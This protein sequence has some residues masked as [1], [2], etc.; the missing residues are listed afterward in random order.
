MRASGVKIVFLVS[1]LRQTGPTMQLL[2][3]VRYLDRN[4]FEPHVVTLSPESGASML[5]S[6]T[7]LGVDVKSL[8]LSRLRGMFHRGWRDD[9]RRAVGA[10]LD[11]GCVIHSQGIRADVISSQR[12]IGVPR[13]ATARNYPHHDYLMKFGPLQGRWMAREHLR[14]FRS[15]PTVVA[16]SST[17]AGL[18]S[19]HGIMATVIRNGV[20]A[21]NFAPPTPQ[22]RA[23][24]R[25][26]LGLPDGA[27]VGVCVG[28]LEPRKDPLHVIRAMRAIDAP[29]LVLV[30]VGGGRLENECRR[31]AQPDPRIRFTG[32]ITNVATYLRAADFIVSASRSEGMPNAILEAIAC[33][34]RVVLSDIE[35]HREL[36]QLVPWAGELFAIDD[37]SALISA[38]G[39]TSL[40]VAAEQARDAA[41]TMAIVGAEQVS[42]Q[43]QEL[44][45]RLADS[46][47]PRR[48]GG[49][50]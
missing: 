29:D 42:Q 10:D 23:R 44:Y 48:A 8:A 49:T 6:F 15:L 16:C 50:A 34:L 24:L 2:N 30:F 47:R 4:L 14:A 18:L 1:T 28:S 45:S 37:T 17:L 39:R 41:R 43:Y 36:L 32:H 5:D 7:G 46:I 33:G 35:P 26:Q 12:L 13:I 27:R 31:L 21:A 20:D 9:I 38:I 22:E 25:A 19:K 3:I 11:H 40:R